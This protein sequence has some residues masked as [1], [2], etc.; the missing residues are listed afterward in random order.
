[1]TGDD[2]NKAPSP[3]PESRHGPVRYSRRWFLVLAAGFIAG[4]AGVVQLFRWLAGGGAVGGGS[5]DMTSDFP[6]LNVED[7][8]HVPASAWVVEVDGLVEQPLR[9]DHVAW[10]ALP[11]VDETGDFHCVEGWSVD[12]L[13]WGGVAP[14]TLLDRAGVKPDGRFIAFHAS[15]GTYVD[16]LSLEQALEPTTLLADALDGAPLPA[17][18][19]G[20]VRL[21][22][23]TQ[24][25]YKNVKWVIRLE[26]TDK[27][28]EGYWEQRGYPRDA[29][30]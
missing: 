22:I 14:R 25:G 20:P 26:V 13:R 16:S 30:V 10:A 7:T 4:A 3:A 8:P 23:P 24:L 17:D 12:N 5:R 2:P 11:H 21:V 9:V 6:T 28:V 1:M 29:P 19:G 18:H 15:G 27:P